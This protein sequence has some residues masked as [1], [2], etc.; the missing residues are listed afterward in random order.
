[1]LV[2]VSGQA[3][4]FSRELFHGFNIS[5]SG[6]AVVVKVNGTISEF[7]DYGIAGDCVRGYTGVAT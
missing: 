2:D 3:A 6:N 7:D 1:M 5:H 4:S